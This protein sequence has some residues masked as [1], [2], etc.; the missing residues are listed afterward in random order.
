MAWS[1]EDTSKPKTKFYPCPPGPHMATCIDVVDLG[2]PDWTK[3]PQNP[4]GAHKVKLVFHVKAL[5]ESTGEPIKNPN[6]KPWVVGQMF[7]MYFGPKSFLRRFVENW[8]GKLTPEQAK[9]FNEDSLVG[10]D[11]YITVTHSEPKINQKGEEVI[12]ANVDS[13]SKPLVGMKGPGL[14]PDYQREKDR[15]KTQ[16]QR[17]PQPASDELGF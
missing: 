6:D 2:T 1:E 15:P 12:Y 14:I 17:R 16:Y 7:T 9:A 10:K 5:D 13:A 4:M 8:I 3:N 11:A